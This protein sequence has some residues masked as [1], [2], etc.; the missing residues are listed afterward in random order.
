MGWVEKEEKP[1][2][3]GYGLLGLCCSS[4]LLGPCRISPFEKVSQ[5]GICGDSPDLMVAKNLFRAV[6]EEALKEL[7]C[8]KEAGEKDLGGRLS[9]EV[10]KLLS[11]SSQDPPTLLEGL[12]PERVFP[13]LYHNPFP[14]RPLMGLLLDSMKEEV[15]GVS[16][17]EG[18]LWKSLQVSIIPLIGEEVRKDADD[19][20]GGKGFFQED[21]QGPSALESLSSDPS[22]VMLLLD[23]RNISAEGPVFQIAQELEKLEKGKIMTLSLPRI[24]ILPGV[25]RRLSEKWGLPVQEMRVLVLISSPLATWT[26]GSLALGFNVISVP[27]LPIHGSERVEK[28]FSEDVKKRFGNTYF[29]PRR[30]DLLHDVLGFLR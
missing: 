11:F 13:S 7:A 22:S 18:I 6:T 8:L 25:G 28:F 26:L 2:A 30:E 19:L 12:L 3:C 23:D 17:V 4:C 15:A 5:K 1:P 20:S 10:G 14:L 16:D 27:D 21:A 9:G 29:S 24:G